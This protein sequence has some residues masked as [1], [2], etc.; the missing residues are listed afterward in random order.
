MTGF[1]ELFDTA[2]DYTLQHT[3]THALVSAVTF[4]LL[5][6]GSGCF[7]DFARGLKFVSQ[8]RKNKARSSAKYVQNNLMD[9]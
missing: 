6:L 5:L 4:S 9:Q 3:H 8:M 2:R 7:L 1:I